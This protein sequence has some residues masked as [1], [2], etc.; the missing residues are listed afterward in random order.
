MHSRN[1]GTFVLAQKWDIVSWNIGRSIA[2]GVRMDDEP[3]ERARNAHGEAGKSSI[4]NGVR[5]DDEPAERAR[6]A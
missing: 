2:N 5:M 1:N 3:A 4:V 6:N